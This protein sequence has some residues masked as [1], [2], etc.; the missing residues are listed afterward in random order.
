MRRSHSRPVLLFFLSLVA[1]VTLD[2]PSRAAGPG[3]KSAA[4]RYT[5]TDLGTLGG[6][7]SFA[8]A[9]NDS[10]QI[11]G[12]SA[13]PVLP[14]G[15]TPSHAFLYRKGV[16]TDLAPLNSGPILTGGPNGIND[17]GLIASGLVVEG[18]YSPAL[19]DSKTGEIT[20]L[21]SLGGIE[22][23]VAFSGVADAVNNNGQAVGL[24][25]VNDRNSHAFLYSD[26]VMTDLSAFDG[27]WSRASG[28]NDRGMIVGTFGFLNGPSHSFSSHAFVYIDGTMIRINPFGSASDQS[29]AT[30]INNK[31]QVV[32]SGLT[33]TGGSRGFIYQDGTITDIGT[34]EG[35]RNSLP[36]DINERGQVV[37]TADRPDMSTCSDPSTC[38][39]VPRAVLYENGELKDLNSL[40]PAASGWDLSYAYGINNRGH[41]T[42]YGVNNG[43]FRA[44]VL[45]PVKHH[46]PHDAEGHRDDQDQ[47]QQDN[48]QD[49]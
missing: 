8:Y 40:I 34:L 22:G 10:G 32:G 45:T 35:G 2:G 37:G 16:M 12:E 19:F 39:Y 4:V 5:V 9:I 31:G 7:Q 18:I 17:E 47:R 20:V 28:I 46:K 43:G 44:F 27:D 36:F 1:I 26:G 49:Q 30:A 41:I 13:L 33:D 14:N 25:F 3:S 29:S 38:R 15:S 42:G 6:T 21:G 11:V 48:D 24:A 23:G